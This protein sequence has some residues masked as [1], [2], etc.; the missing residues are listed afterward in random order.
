[1]FI[2]AEKGISIYRHVQQCQ[3]L[4]QFSGDV[5]DTEFNGTKLRIRADSNEDDIYTIFELKREVAKLKGE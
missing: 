3:R 2:Q 1:M 4:A 5:V